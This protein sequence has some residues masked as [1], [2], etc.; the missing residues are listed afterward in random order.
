MRRALRTLCVVAFALAALTPA[1]ALDR[2]P[3]EMEILVDGIPLP[4]YAARGTTYIEALEG[5]EFS[6]RLTNRT[7]RRIAVALS[8]DGLNTIDAKTTTSRD[9]AKWILGPHQTVTLDGWQTGASTA[10][11]FFF[12]TEERSYGSWLGQTR[13]LGIISSAVF[14]EQVHPPAPIAA[15]QLREDESS[16]GDRKGKKMRSEAPRSSLE[17]AGEPSERS[18][19]DADDM[20]ATGIGQQ[21]DHRVRRVRFD[22]EAAPA[23]TM[24]VRYEYRPV[25]VRLGVLPRP[26]FRYDDPLERRERA[27]GF[28]EPA[29]APDPYRRR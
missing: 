14:R 12:T 29:F 6:I 20:A 16:S 28:E 13:N 26:Y 5:R 18:R 10:R 15:P 27:R 9:A 23:A 17:G 1:A 3:Y 24:Q 2:G 25:L 19:Q 22:A 4:E 7:D 8:V 21:I 11:R